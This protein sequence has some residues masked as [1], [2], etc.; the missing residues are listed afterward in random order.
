[1]TPPSDAFRKTKI[2]FQ[3]YVST[4]LVVHAKLRGA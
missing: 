1:M 3:A 4:S 2:L